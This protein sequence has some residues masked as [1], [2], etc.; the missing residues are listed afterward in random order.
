MLIYDAANIMHP[1]TKYDSLPPQT[2]L[3]YGEIALT[4]VSQ[5]KFGA[6][7]FGEFDAEKT[8]G[9]EE[10]LYTKQ[11]P[12]VNFYFE[13]HV[14]FTQQNTDMEIIDTFTASDDSYC[15]TTRT[16]DKGVCF[17]HIL[18][19]HPWDGS[20]GQLSAKLVDGIIAGA[21]GPVA[22]TA[23]HRSDD[24]EGRVIWKNN[25]GDTTIEFKYEIDLSEADT[26]QC[27][28]IDAKRDDLPLQFRYELDG[29]QEGS[30]VPAPDGAMCDAVCL[31]L[32]PQEEPVTLTLHVQPVMADWD[33]CILN[34]QFRVWEPERAN[35]A[36]PDTEP[37]QTFTF[38]EK[39]FVDEEFQP[40]GG[41]TYGC[42]L[43][44]TDD[45][46][47]PP[48]EEITFSGREKQ[49]YLSTQLTG[50]DAAK[51][52]NYMVFVKVMQNDREVPFAVTEDGEKKLVQCI[53]HLPQGEMNP[54]LTPLYLDLDPAIAESKLSAEI[55]YQPDVIQPEYRYVTAFAD[56]NP[57]PYTHHACSIVVAKYE[58][59]EE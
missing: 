45:S 58:A 46:A 28:T 15:G 37:A 2:E 25:D 23:S 59:A 41:Y 34:T 20:K 16:E 31:N 13:N 24:S 12:Y 6:F 55:W 51:G 11:E 19:D 35:A 48:A 21:D 22:I 53:G 57:I 38:S 44:E 32:E 1:N 47:K 26:L 56:N 5:T 9:W 36:P 42:S 8:Q 4:Q 7:Y 3:D 33:E 52:E 27:I 10:T 29:S 54:T 18:F 43:R 14:E 40:D 30:A 49:L 50:Q 39:V 17:V